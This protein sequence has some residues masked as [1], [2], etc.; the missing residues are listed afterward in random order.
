MHESLTAL[1]CLNINAK[2]GTQFV[3]VFRMVVMIKSDQFA[4]QH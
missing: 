3:I 1:Y 4:T 2:H